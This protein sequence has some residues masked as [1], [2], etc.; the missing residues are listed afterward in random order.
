MCDANA[1]RRITGIA[2]FMT[3][4]LSSQE[5]AV[6]CFLFQVP[7]G[8]IHSTIDSASRCDKKRVCAFVLVR[9]S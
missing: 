1:R 9:L 5:G 2:A 3:L 8:P 7:C 4:Y 6:N